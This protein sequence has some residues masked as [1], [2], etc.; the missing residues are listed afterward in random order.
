MF[1]IAQ[2]GR[3]ASLRLLALVSLIFWI[4]PTLHADI[5]M[6]PG[7][8]KKSRQEKRRDKEMQERR[9][10]LSAM[11]PEVIP[12]QVSFVE[13]SSVEIELEA[14]TAVAAGL[15]FLIRDEPKHGTLSNLRPHPESRFKALITY[16]HRS[17]DGLMDRF[18]YACRLGDGPV[19]A[20]GVVT[21]SGK[22]AEP[23]LEVLKQPMFE[24]SLPGREVMAKAVVRNSGIGPFKEA[25]TWPEGWKGP[26]SLELAVGESAELA[27]FYTPKEPGLHTSEVTLQTDVPESR[28]RLWLQCEQPFEVTPNRAQMEFDPE[29]SVRWVRVKV[30]N[31]TQEN[32]RLSIIRPE[33]LKGPAEVEVRPG[34]LSEIEFILPDADVESFSGEVLLTDGVLSERLT[35]GA[36]PEPAQIRLVSPVTSELNFGRIDE[37]GSAEQHLVLENVGGQAGI[38]AIQVPPPFQVPEEE[39]ALSVPPGSRRDLVLTASGAIAGRYGG[40][41]IVT[42]QTGGRL[43]VKANAEFVDPKL[44]APAA[45]GA[46]KATAPAAGNA[47]PP[48]RPA[49]VKAAAVVMEEPPDKPLAAAPQTTSPTRPQRPSTVMGVLPPAAAGMLSYI[50]VFG[51]P[52][53]PDQ[54]SER[55]KKITNLRLERRARNELDITWESPPVEFQ[56]QKYIVQQAR[57]EYNPDLK[58]FFRQW[59]NVTSAQ[60]LPARDGRIGLRLT[61]LEPGSQYSVRFLG[62]D[63]LER[64][65]EPSDILI[66]STLPPFRIP[67]WVWLL[68]GL[69]ALAA[70]LA[71]LRSRQMSRGMSPATGTP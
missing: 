55:L 5:K 30:S 25:L 60:A 51:M 44:P 32:L 68:L 67:G 7:D 66:V 19:S 61:D 59:V 9:E 29:R 34:L 53:P 38:V 28:I 16:T 58:M 24:K 56:P 62:V 36:S 15:Q 27:L 13:G 14:A 31:A 47:R 17:G 57:Q 2:R 20:P 8:E 39:G 46:A 49:A 41:I 4:G 11:I 37:G 65:S 50:S 45:A 33:R 63:E 54:M 1:A 6:T 21:L 3:T 18:S 26:R 12:T 71:Y 52:L 35:L 48:A 22:A 42:N 64:F 23:R 40:S 70:V 43:E 10:Q 69:S